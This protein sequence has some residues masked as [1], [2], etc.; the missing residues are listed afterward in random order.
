MLFCPV[1]KQ[2]YNTTSFLMNHIYRYYQ[3]DNEHKEFF[4]DMF[5][6]FDNLFY[7]ISFYKY[8]KLN[9]PQFIDYEAIITY[10]NH[11][12]GKQL[13]RQRN[14]IVKRYFKNP[15]NIEQLNNELNSLKKPQL[16]LPTFDFSKIKENKCPVCHVSFGRSLYGHCNKSFDIHKNFISQQKEIAY[17]LKDRFLNQKFTADELFDLGFAFNE[18]LLLKFMKEKFGKPLIEQ[19]R[20][21]LEKQ[22]KQNPI[23]Q[24]HNT[25]RKGTIKVFSFNEIEDQLLVPQ[26]NFQHNNRYYRQ[27]DTNICE[28]CGSDIHKTTLWNHCVLNRNDEQHLKFLIEQSNNMLDAFNSLNI[29]ANKKSMLEHFIYSGTDKMKLIWKTFF[30]KEQIKL[31]SLILRREKADSSNIKN[32]KSLPQRNECPFCH[33]DCFYLYKHIEKYHKKEFDNIIQEQILPL[34]HTLAS[35]NEDLLNYNIPQ[36]FSWKHILNIWQTHFSEQEY[37]YRKEHIRRRNVNIALKMK[38]LNISKEEAIKLVDQIDVNTYLKTCQF[39]GDVLNNYTHYE[40]CCKESKQFLEQQVRKCIQVFDNLIINDSNLKDFG[41]TF[42]LRDVHQIWKKYLGE[43]FYKIRNDMYTGRNTAIAKFGRVLNDYSRWDIENDDTLSLEQLIEKHVASIK[44]YKENNE[45]IKKFSLSKGH[46]IPRKDI[47]NVK[48]CR[49]TWEANIYRILNYEHKRFKTEVPFKLPDI[50]HETKRGYKEYFVDF[51]DVDN[52]FGFGENV[53][54]EIKGQFGDDAQNKSNLFQQCYPDKK[55]V[56]IGIDDPT[57]NFYPEIKYNEL[58]DKYKDIIPLWETKQF[59]VFNHPQNFLPENL[60]DEKP[61]TII[62]SDDFNNSNLTP[63]QKRSLSCS[64]ARKPNNQLYGFRY[65]LNDNFYSTWEANIARIF[66]YENKRFET[67]I[68]FEFMLN[69]EPVAIIANFK[70]VDNCFG[71]GSNSYLKIIGFH[72]EKDEKIRALKQA[73]NNVFIISVPTDSKNLDID[74]ELLKAKY[75][76]LIPLWE[77]KLINISTA[78]EFYKQELTEEM[79]EKLSQRKIYPTCNLCHKQYGKTLSYHL[80]N[81]HDEAHQKLYKEQEQLIVSH[82]HK[83]ELCNENDLE[84]LGILLN[85]GAVRDIWHKYFSQDEI[86]ERALRVNAL[87][88]KR[89]W[90][91]SPKRFIKTEKYLQSRLNEKNTKID[92]KQFIPFKNKLIED[93]LLVPEFRYVPKEELNIVPYNFDM[94]QGY[95]PLCKQQGKHEGIGNGWHAHLQRYRLKDEEHEKLF[96]QQV[97]L[98]IRLFYDLNYT[99][100]NL[101]DDL[102]LYFSYNQCQEIWKAVF[103]DEIKERI[104]WNRKIGRARQGQPPIVYNTKNKWKSFCTNRQKNGVTH[105]IDWNK[106]DFKFIDY[107]MIHYANEYF[108]DAQN[109]ICPICKGKISSNRTLYD[110]LR[111]KSFCCDLHKQLFEEQINLIYSLFKQNIDFKNNPKQFNVL[112]KY[113]TCKYLFE[114]VNAMGM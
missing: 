92:Y 55:L 26:I 73:F 100:D 44:E 50:N 77:D 89:A 105:N 95:C 17:S 36:W 76:P 87:Q 41:I 7:N 58:E 53:C 24:P 93:K 86:K 19:R 5:I 99:T 104:T 21:N 14:N 80:I 45:I 103:P 46:L 4:Q 108:E 97:E 107:K 30:S 96:Q 16:K 40:N 9:F 3:N 2:K 38:S 61:M 71:F 47:P 10:W 66:K 52:F 74:Y 78:P 48:G 111:H 54:I 57:H 63:N 113:D 25:N 69:N 67:N 101:N 20:L 39:C 23:K 81:T 27:Y 56:F 64:L 83:L 68:G 29:K 15:Q 106:F 110:H 35:N 79:K 62:K 114:I 75:Q 72:K 42:S 102:H 60:I 70:D 28:F 11:E 32:C 85:F 33:A 18:K 37:N 84:K 13:I 31:R 51:I 112:F 91:R 34:F 43:E 22:S 6:Q 98:V 49:S 65:D 109:K 88:Q 82:F 1:C 59:S 8:S 12:F 94:T 90:E